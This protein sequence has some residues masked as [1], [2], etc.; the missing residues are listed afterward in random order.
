MGLD[1]PSLLVLLT[2]GLDS[3]AS[4]VM[5]LWHPEMAAIENKYSYLV[6]WLTEMAGWPINA[7][8]LLSGTPIK[9]SLAPWLFHINCFTSTL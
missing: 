3:L 1:C 4:G 2:V 9:H 5:L 8:I 7:R 6:I